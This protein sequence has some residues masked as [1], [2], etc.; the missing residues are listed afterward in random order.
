MKKEKLIAGSVDSTK[1]GLV[2][3]IAR[4]TGFSQKD[5]KEVLSSFQRCVLTVLKTE[6][7]VRLL[8]LGKLRYVDSPERTAINP[9]TKEQILVPA[10]KTPKFT[11]SKK[12]KEF[13]NDE[14]D[15]PS[16]DF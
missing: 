1:K 13:V 6:R 4:N 15:W 7:E 5:I 9:K 2:S 8:D 16:F 10:K 11:F 14:E 12:V 3:E